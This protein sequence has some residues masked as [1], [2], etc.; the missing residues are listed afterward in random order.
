MCGFV[1]FISAEGVGDA[2]E[3]VHA[4][5]CAIRHRG[6]DDSVV[7][8][9]QPGVTMGFQRLAIIDVAGSRQPL[10]H[11]GRWDLCFNGEVYNYRELREELA[12]E[13]GAVFATAG[14][15]EV[16]AAAFH[17]WGPGAVRRLR[18]MFAY[19][20]WDR[21]ERRLHA[22][23]D[24]FGIKPLHY[25]VTP[26]GL[27]LASERKSLPGGGGVD[28]DALAHYVSLQY[29]PEPYTMD[30]AVRRVPAGHALTW[31]PGGQV[32]LDRHFRPGF[33]PRAGVSEQELTTRVRDAL[34]DSV[35]AH[36]VAD[37]PVGA[38]LSGGVDSSAVVALASEVKPDL[39]VFSAGFDI[40]GY[41]ELDL[42]AETAQGLGL[43]FTPTVVTAA[44]VLRELPRIAWHLD[45]PLA[46]PS[47]IPLFFLARTASRQVRVVLSGEGADELFGG[48]EIYRE[49][50]ATA[51][52]QRL[53]RAVQGT[54]RQVSRAMPEG[55][56]GKSYL[57]RATTPLEQRYYGNARIFDAEQKARLLHGR[58]AVPRTAVTDE[59][60][61]ETAHLDPVSRMQL[62][63]LH[64]WLPGDILT[65]ADRM[66]MA[67][68]LELRVPFLDQR[69][70]EAA[71][72]VPAALRV[73]PDSP[74]TK[75]LLRAAVAGLLPAPV[76]Q[77]RKLGFATPARVW[78]R[79]D[80]GDWAHELLSRSAAGAH[81]DLAYARSLLVAHQRGE[82]DH[83]RKV[84]TVLMFCLWHAI[85]VERSIDPFAG[86][87]RPVPVAGAAR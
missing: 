38:F 36:M 74:Q 57:D 61:A 54:L 12:R 9:P 48:Y 31:E 27:W 52:V 40:P 4:G 42:A 21:Q 23:R 50:F 53:P 11:A 67:H 45:D 44:D 78:L 71:A 83:S 77:R 26:A 5:L 10:T 41:S 80:I 68:S 20:L 46:D 84:W 76:A 62:V 85:F 60:Y 32:R 87:A 56:R 69:V 3:V 14:D 55:V 35:R 7:T 33:A 59:V 18:G 28:P 6:P 8:V 13:F 39:Q 19:A 86:T 34:R 79:G 51:P 63:D 30:R 22:G 1:V 81:L 66:S 58:P 15:A 43:R 65:K 70:W 73:S 47:L 25:A 17:H 29:V 37:V 72:S 49:P 64:T 82:A 24:P 75:R 16:L 2:R